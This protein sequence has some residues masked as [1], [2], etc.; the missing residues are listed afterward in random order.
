MVTP[1]EPTALVKSADRTLAIL[2][3]LGDAREPVSVTDLHRLTGFPRS[4]LHQLLHTMAARRWIEFLNDGATVGITSRALLTGTAYLDRDRALPHGSRTL[5]KLR[6][7]T[8]YTTHYARLDGD[9]VLY[10]ETR[11]TSDSHRSTSRVGRI[12]PANATALGKALFAER[13][14]REVLE[15]LGPGPYPALTEHTIT[16]PERILDSLARVREV[17][18]AVEREENTIGISCVSAVVPYRIPATDAIS[19][20]IPIHRVDD[21]EILRVAAALRECVEE[22][23]QLLRSSGIR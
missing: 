8:G 19:C 21:A 22:L 10:L 11:E 14:E 15:A 18:Y 5:E 20:S 13:S 1:T 7:Q 6:Q 16:D 23:G 9:S 4:S 17:G 2:E 12:L 3:I